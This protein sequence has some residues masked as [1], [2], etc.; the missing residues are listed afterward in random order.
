MGKNIKGG[1]KTKKQKNSTN[2]DVTN[3]IT[4]FRDKSQGQVYGVITKVYGGG[5]VQVSFVDDINFDVGQKQ[6]KLG[7]IR[8]SS[9]KGKYKYNLINVKIGDVILIS[10]RSYD[11]DKVD[12]LYRYNDYDINVLRKGKHINEQ[13][14][15]N[16]NKNRN[17][18]NTNNNN[19]NGDSG[20]EFYDEDDE[21]LDEAEMKYKMRRRISYSDI[22]NELEND[23]SLS[24]ENESV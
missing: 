2:K 14:L 20:P 1:N 23:N 22:F 17:N 10:L 16:T 18:T 3:K 15:E 7:I 9:K 19:D 4:D 6:I 5:R 13:L 21:V 24:S 12:V 8:G 11:K